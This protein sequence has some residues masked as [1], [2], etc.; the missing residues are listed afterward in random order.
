MPPAAALTLLALAVLVQRL[1]ELRL[2]RH[3]EQWARSRGAVEYGARHYPAFFVLHAG[4]LAAWLSEASIRGPVLAGGWPA[5]LA[6]FVGA[7]MLRY[8]AIGSLG[9][10]W[11]T[12]ILVLPGEPPVRRGPYR[13]L[14]HPN[15][16]AVAVELAA[17]PLIFDA[18]VTALV[19]GIL[20]AALL[21]AVRIPAE[22]RALD[23]AAGRPGAGPH[24]AGP[25]AAPPPRRR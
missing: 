9:P 20:N 8:W 14:R 19:A 21:L 7:E 15:Y 5:W 23:S 4:W 16:L 1:L 12:R 10:R 6:L 13:Y 11:N 2:A 25:A 3:N 24:T 17:V 22:E 18:W